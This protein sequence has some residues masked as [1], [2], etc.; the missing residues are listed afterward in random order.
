MRLQ[1]SDETNVY[2]E[3]FNSSG[4]TQIRS[5]DGSSNGIFSLMGNNGTTDQYFL[6]IDAS[7]DVGIGTSGPNIGT[8]GNALTLDSGGAASTSCALEL[9]KSGTLYGFLG[10]QGSGSS[11]ALDIAAYQSQ[12]IRLRVGSSAGTTAMTVNSD[13]NVGIGITPGSAYRLYVSGKPVRFIS[14]GA[15]SN[16]AVLELVHANNN[17]TDVVSTL[18]FANNVGA[19][20]HIQGGTTG[21]NTNGYISFHTDDS[22]TSTERMRITSDGR[23][24]VDS[25][26]QSGLLY[27][28]V[29][30]FFHNGT[31]SNGVKIK[32]NFPFDSANENAMPTIIIEG[33]DYR[34]ARTI[35][36]QIA[37][38]PY[39]SSF[40]QGTVSSFGSYTPVVKLAREDDKVIIHLGT[41]ETD[42]YYD[43][44]NVR[45]LHNFVNSDQS[46]ELIGWTWADEAIT[47]DRIATLTYNNKVG[48]LTTEGNV[49]IGTSSLNYP[50]HGYRGKFIY[51]FC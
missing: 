38:Y 20:A 32:T 15:A 50:P 31:I 24:D 44:F 33:Y 51:R 23:V 30:Q 3:I 11:N 22:G 16:G 19:V 34:G 27:H 42:W 26:L 49:G 35:G 9:S 40:I 2:T 39:S 48:N 6:R 47:G 28:N 25:I 43:S 1:D 45:V 21:G 18:A 12:D 4:D 46:S 17:S 8:W 41:D 10:V 7:G 37:W 29:L 36:L 5:R 14:D 13:G